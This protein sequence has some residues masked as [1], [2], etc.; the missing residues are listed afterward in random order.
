[1]IT[2]FS[3]PMNILYIICTYAMHCSR[4]PIISK[5]GSFTGLIDYNCSK[6]NVAFAAVDLLIANNDLVFRMNLWQ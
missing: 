2:P 3:G 1:M 5:Y 6:H 4:E